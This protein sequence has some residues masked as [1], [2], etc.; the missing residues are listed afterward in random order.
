MA[1]VVLQRFALGLFQYRVGKGRVDR[2]L[3]FYTV[4]QKLDE[5]PQFLPHF[6]KAE[7]VTP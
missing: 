6:F 2:F 4:H 1:A 3:P 5:F 7:K